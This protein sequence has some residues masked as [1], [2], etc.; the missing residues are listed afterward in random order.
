M[1]TII[2]ILCVVMAILIAVTL[3]A[4]A[5]AMDLEE[6]L[7][8]VNSEY[9]F[10]NK[11]YEAVRRYCIKDSGRI[12][13]DK[14]FV[15]GWLNMMQNI[16]TEKWYYI[17]DETLSTTGCDV[18][19]DIIT[20]IPCNSHVKDDVYDQLGKE[21]ADMIINRGSKEEREAFIKR[22][23]DIIDSYKEDGK[24]DE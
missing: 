19:G 24:E 21:Y 23:M 9:S 10:L 3:M 16:H 13:V 18:D 11:K 12:P 15:V 1:K 7:K 14:Y 8:K 20:I 22:S 6:K 4:V 2:F 17:S 5:T